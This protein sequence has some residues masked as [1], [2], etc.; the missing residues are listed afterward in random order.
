MIRPKVRAFALACV[1]FPAVLS[2]EPPAPGFTLGAYVPEACPVY[3]HRRNNPKRQFIN[4]KWK[5]II[6]AVKQ[7]GLLEEL[8]NNLGSTMEGQARERFEEQWARTLDMVRQVSW[9]DLWQQ[10]FVFAMRFSPVPGFV[11]LCEGRPGTG[12]SNAA[13]LVAV[14][15]QCAAGDEALAVCRQKCP[16]VRMATLDL[17]GTPVALQVIQRA[18]TLVLCTDRLLA[19]EVVKLMRGNRRLR[20]VTDS[21]RFQQALESLPPAEDMIVYADWRAMLTGLRELLGSTLE[22]VAHGE[23]RDQAL[24]VLDKIMRRIDVLDYSLKVVRTEGLQQHTY[25]VTALQPDRVQAKLARALAEREPLQDPLRIVPASATA[26]S[27]S[28]GADLEMIYSLIR[29][30]VAEDLPHGT[31][32]LERWDALQARVGF[33]VQGDLLSWLDGRLMVIS[34]RPK[35]P[36]PFGGTDDVL[37]LGVKD[38]ALAR[39]KVQAG[40]VRLQGLALEHLK[41][42][43]LVSPAPEVHGEGFQTVF[44]P[45]FAILGKP[46]IGVQGRWLVWGTSA[47]AVNQVIETASGRAPSI[48]EQPRFRRE[49]LTLEGSVRSVS[50]ADLGDLGRQLAQSMMMP[51]I[52]L[53]FMPQNEETGPARALLST[54]A[55]AGPILGMIDFY[56]SSA[57]TTTFDGRSWRTEQVVTYKDGD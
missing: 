5:R 33:D 44:S 45:L 26:F 10:E 48:K 18:D 47:S 57:S 34:L 56:S 40:L 20:S 11:V 4:R 22:R 46:V 25:S 49:G 31:D 50:F 15:D 23:D 39:K 53:G 35:Q 9:G 2:A 16:G 7:A 28:T 42:P 14:L 37:L 55:R 21:P 24:D 54:M 51:S 38:V 32:V 27:A 52:M 3:V 13:S 43:L 41:Q 1:A 36:K 29:D 19:A 17:P 30:V 6:T 8:K 12:S